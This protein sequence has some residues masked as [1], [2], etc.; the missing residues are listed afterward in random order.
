VIYVLKIETKQTK[1]IKEIMTLHQAVT[2]FAAILLIII[3]TPVTLTLAQGTSCEDVVATL[4][5]T[6][7]SRIDQQELVEA[8]RN[9]NR[10]SNKK[11]PSKFVTKSE[12]RTRGWKPGEN[13]W[14]ING[15]KGSS[16]GGDQFKNLESR[17]PASRWREADLDYKGGHRGS[18]RLV[19]SKDGRRFVTVDHYRTF[20]EIPA[21]Q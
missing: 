16:I 18:K 14:S 4:G 21:C 8:L 20:A 19:F 17:L 3:L 15:L 12:A 9:L 6:L 11:L 1:A 13:L 5:D 7:S 2:R 10:T